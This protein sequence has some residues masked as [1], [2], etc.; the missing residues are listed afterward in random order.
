MCVQ[1]GEGQRERGREDPK[2]G[3]S[4]ISAESYMGFEPANGKMVT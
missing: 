2:Q 1:V 3:F 4:A